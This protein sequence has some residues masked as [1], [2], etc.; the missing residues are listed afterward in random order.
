MTSA[1]P[2]CDVRRSDSVQPVHSWKCSHTTD[3]FSPLLAAATISAALVE[4]RPTAAAAI[5]QTLTKSRRVCI[6]LSLLD[7]SVRRCLSNRSAAVK[8]TERLEISRGPAKMADRTA[9]TPATKVCQR[10]NQPE[11]RSA[12]ALLRITLDM[13]F[14]TVDGNE[15]AARIAYPLSEVIAIYPIAPS[16]TMGEFADAWA[17]DKRPNL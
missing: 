16:S 2:G 4:D 6:P 9:G 5:V 17:G 7:G 8:T 3:G 14:I 15:A 11:I 10:A 1:M 12:H 13:A